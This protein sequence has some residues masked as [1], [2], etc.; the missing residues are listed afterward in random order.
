MLPEASHVE[1][2]GVDHV[3]EPPDANHPAGLLPMSALK[4]VV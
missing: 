1:G 2:L 4:G 3:E